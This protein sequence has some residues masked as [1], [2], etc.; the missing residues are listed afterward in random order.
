MKNNTISQHKIIGVPPKESSELYRTKICLYYSKGE[1]CK[2]RDKCVFAHGEK[3]LRVLV[4]E[5]QK[6]FDIFY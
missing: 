3:E 6:Y 5:I 4:S 2:F 1:D